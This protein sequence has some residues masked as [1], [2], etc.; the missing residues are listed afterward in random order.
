MSII[1]CEE[2][3]IEYDSD[4]VECPECIIDDNIESLDLQEMP[5]YKEMKRL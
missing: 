3:D 2:H 5:G 1:R 4:L